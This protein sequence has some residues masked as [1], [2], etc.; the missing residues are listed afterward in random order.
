MLNQDKTIEDVV[1]QSSLFEKSINITN[2]YDSL[3]KNSLFHKDDA[4]VKFKLD[5]C[6]ACTNKLKCLIGNYKFSVDYE[7]G[8][9]TYGE[10]DVLIKVECYDFD[11]M[12]YL[13]EMDDRYG[14]VQK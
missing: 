12:D 11:P 3:K 8:M 10:R 9:N 13:K 6:V 4:T 5:V 1:L 2:L 14:S 7:P